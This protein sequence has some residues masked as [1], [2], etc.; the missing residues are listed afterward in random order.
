VLLD[1]CALLAYALRQP[2]R[3]DAVK[4]LTEAQAEDR[5]LVSSISA[6]EIAQKSATRRM[7]LVDGDP[8]AWFAR[9]V[10]RLG[11]RELPLGAATAFAA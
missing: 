7:G 6:L 11:I 2:M 3:A 10:R 1:N 4:A 5:L 8:A 9:A